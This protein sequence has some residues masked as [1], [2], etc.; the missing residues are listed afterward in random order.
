MS[1]E[2]KLKLQAIQD[3]LPERLTLR[4]F[5]TPHGCVENIGNGYSMSW[6]TLWDM[7]KTWRR[8]EPHLYEGVDGSW[9]VLM[10]GNPVN[11]WTTHP[12]LNTLHYY[13]DLDTAVAATLLGR[14]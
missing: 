7:M 1:I 3:R 10:P 13:P 14:G 9:W 2:D 8:F 5:I 12:G 4:Y 6:V 11:D